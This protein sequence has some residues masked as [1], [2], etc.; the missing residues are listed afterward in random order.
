M[1]ESF[2]MHVSLVFHL[3][4][5][6]EKDTLSVCKLVRTFSWSRAVRK[7]DEGNLLTA[8]QFLEAQWEWIDF[9][10]LVTS[11]ANRHGKPDRKWSSF[12]GGG[13][14]S[15][16]V[17]GALAAHPELNISGEQ[18]TLRYLPCSFRIKSFWTIQWSGLEFILRFKDECLICNYFVCVL[19]VS[20][21]SGCDLSF[22]MYVLKA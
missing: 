13:P 2:L 6:S 5:S 18:C 16:P 14:T 20:N 9:L 15:R 4:S 8:S 21:H 1:S 17:V 19:W 11:I 22:C 10:L 12:R 7:R 3:L